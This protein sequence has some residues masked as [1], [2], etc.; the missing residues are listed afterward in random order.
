MPSGLNAG[1]TLPS[2]LG[3][4]LQQAVDYHSAGRLPEAERLYRVILGANS[5]EPDAAHNL[6]VLLLQQGRSEAALPFLRTALELRP[7]EEQRW[8]L[9]METLIHLDRPDDAKSLLIQA[10]QRGHWSAALEVIADRLS[11]ASWS[12]EMRLIE[13]A[14]VHDGPE[15]VERV[16]RSL[17]EERPSHALGWKALGKALWRLHR[18]GEAL[19]ATDKALALSPLD[20]AAHYQLGC[21]QFSLGRTEDAVASYREVLR[22]NSGFVE[23]HHD[24]AVI[25]QRKGLTHQAE[26][27]YLR[28]LELRP[29]FIEALNNLAWLYISRGDFLAA[30]P[31]VR[32]SLEVSDSLAGQQAFIACARRMAWLERD[33]WICDT[34]VRA[35]TEPWGRPNDLVGPS[36]GIIKLNPTIRNCLKTASSTWGEAVLA[37]TP[38][39]SEELAA[40]SS[41]RV[42]AALMTTTSNCDLELERFLTMAR[43]SLL[44]IAELD[45]ATLGSTDLG[46][47][48]FCILARQCFIN[49]YVFSV[50]ARERHQ[51]EESRNRLSTL[52]NLREKPSSLLVLSVASYTPLSTIP[53]A[54]ELLSFDWPEP[55]LPVLTQQITEPALELAERDSIPR[56]TAIDDEISLIVRQQYEEN[57][58][59]RWTKFTSVRQSQEVNEYFHSRFPESFRSLA[60]RNRSPEIL[61][62]G[63][64]TGQ[65]SISTALLFSDGKLLAID[66]SLSSLC[67][68]KRKSRE[69]G[70][71]NIE[72]AQ[73]DI[74]RINQIDRRFDLIESIG[75]LHHLADADSGW[76]LLLSLLRPGGCMKIG[77]YSDIARRR[78]NK[79]KALADEKGYLGS[80]DDIRQ[81]RQDIIE[82]RADPEFA[83]F[84]SLIDF[85]STSDCRDLL[86]HVKEHRTNLRE[87]KKFIDKNGLTFLGFE[88]DHH[89]LFAYRTRFPN[90]PSA[91]DLLQWEKFENENPDTFVGMYM[92]WVQ[93][94]R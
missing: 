60:P 26:A 6:G 30:L 48:F 23:A 34:L 25:H 83:H 93:K 68:A 58:Y 42:F 43:A 79:V 71:T 69:L 92:F 63:C 5:Q 77:L 80:T 90:D 57:P 31:Q 36:A 81:C 13:A 88:M 4:L 10:R 84:L 76:P 21:I 86:F 28:A 50:T 2:E 61:I 46:L 19:A 41:D 72:Y 65:H 40:F 14:L 82:H 85:F 56:L 38:F 29:D 33:Q 53:H 22:L 62:A 78:L 20:P 70:I 47:S 44:E 18:F 35:L 55:I 12:E 45:D 94:Q 24:I 91:S 17:V 32:R 66:L 59:P 39:S 37:G 87:I 89:V 11:R 8:R 52:L 3:R 1:W 54:H 75:V 51:F 49:E 73:A 16:A 67:Y 9:C 15:A 7:E 74:L 64:G 27:S